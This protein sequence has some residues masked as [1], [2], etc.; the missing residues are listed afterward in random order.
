M[1]VTLVGDFLT[2][3]LLPDHFAGLAVQTKHD[4]LMKFGRLRSVARDF[5]RVGRMP[6]LKFD[7]GELKFEH[8]GEFAAVPS[9]E[10][11]CRARVV[12]AQRVG[13][14]ILRRLVGDSRK[15]CA[16]WRWKGR[17]WWY[18]VLARDLR[19]TPSK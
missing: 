13:A 11:I 6:T 18:N 17:K 2:R 3:G 9:L 16:N 19:R 7:P 1:A 4:E 10:V 14:Q 5:E 8:N 12:W 15:S